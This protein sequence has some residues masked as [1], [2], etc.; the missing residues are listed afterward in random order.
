MSEVPQVINGENV[1]ISTMKSETI[2][3]NV[4]IFIENVNHF[5]ISFMK[6]SSKGDLRIRGLRD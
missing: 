2:Y 4:K 5:Q 6:K 3:E 1:K